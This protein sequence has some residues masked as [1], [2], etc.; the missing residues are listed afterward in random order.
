M[1]CRYDH[2]SHI[3][4]IMAELVSSTQSNS[5]SFVRHASVSV[6]L[7]NEWAYL[8]TQGRDEWSNFPGYLPTVVP[9]ILDL[10]KGMNQKITFFI[11]G[12]DALS[13]ENSVAFSDISRAGHE[14]AN[15]SFLHEPWLHLYDKDELERDFDQSEAAIENATGFRPMGFRGPGFSTSAAVR[16]ML[17][18]RGYEYDSSMFPT[19]MGPVARTYFMMRSNLS[20]EEKKKRSG[21]Y[22]SFSDAVRTLHP[23]EIEPGLMEVPV[24]TMPLTRLPVHLSYL[25]FLAQYSDG[26]A[27]LYWRMAVTLCRVQGVAPTLLLHPTDFLDS[28]DVPR[29]DFFPAMGVPAAR[30]IALVRFAISQLQKHWATGTVV[31]HARSAVPK[32]SPSFKSHLIESNV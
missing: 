26:L 21:L 24:T 17:R 22:G 1:I 6:D 31:D 4:T 32:R 8:K 29:M 12:K 23:Y 13:P 16:Q 14:I 10:M 28:S 19:V 27:R 15:H 20:P 3:T 11:V 30:K 5:L 9:R 25:L 18:D 2:N 7:D